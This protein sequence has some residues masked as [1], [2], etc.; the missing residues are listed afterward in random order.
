MSSINVT[1]EERL[2]VLRSNWLFSTHFE[3][4]YDRQ[5]ASLSALDPSKCDKQFAHAGANSG[6]K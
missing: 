2:V 4:S 1:V 5:T 3:T 6:I